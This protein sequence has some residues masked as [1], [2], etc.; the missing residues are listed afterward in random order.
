MSEP[1]QELQTKSDILPD[2]PDQCG[3]GSYNLYVDD[4]GFECCRD[5]GFKETWESIREIVDKNFNEPKQ[6]NRDTLHVFNL[7]NQ[8]IEEQSK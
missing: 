1:K 6:S 5:C 7:A 8:N 4:E 2:G 3:C